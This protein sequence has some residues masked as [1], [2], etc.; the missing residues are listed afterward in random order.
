MY[1]EEDRKIV[2][3]IIHLA[4]NLGLKVIAEG[5]EEL[6]QILL[7]KELSC[8][9]VQGFYYAKPMPSDEFF[10]FLQTKR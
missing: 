2:T 9:E 8:E 3:S 4:H 1:S 5:T 6:D 7:L 10:A